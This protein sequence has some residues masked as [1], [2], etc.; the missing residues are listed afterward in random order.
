M[1][2]DNL[3]KRFQPFDTSHL[4]KLPFCYSFFP[5]A[6]LF[7]NFSNIYHTVKHLNR[8]YIGMTACQ[9]CGKSYFLPGK[10]LWVLFAHRAVLCVV[11]YIL[12][13]LCGFFPGHHV[14]K[15]VVS[16]CDP[17]VNSQLVQSLT[18]SSPAEQLE[19]DTMTLSAERAVAENKKDPT[20]RPF[21]LLSL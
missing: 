13:V 20:F 16:L 14:C 5:M 18:L 1:G 21:Y 10:C 3:E 11:L 9:L 7:A 6:I 15:C 4:G 19:W 8:K 2:G 17:A 12:L